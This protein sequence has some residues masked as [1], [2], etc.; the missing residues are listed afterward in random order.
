MKTCTQCGEHRFPDQFVRSNKPNPDVCKL[1]RAKNSR[2]AYLARNQHDSEKN[3]VAAATR[4]KKQNPDKVRQYRKISYARNPQAWIAAARKREHAKLRRTPV[5]EAELTEFVTTE[6]LRLRDLR[7]AT[8]GG[9]WEVD[10]VVPLQG[11]NVSGL[12]VWNNLRVIPR[13][14]NRSKHNRYDVD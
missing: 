11:K 10:H 2:A 13:A 5:W 6:A 7:A 9:V 3:A 4:W 14:M 12:H 1:C 8:I